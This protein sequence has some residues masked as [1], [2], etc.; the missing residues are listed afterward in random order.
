MVRRATKVR[1]TALVGLLAAI[2]A[3]YV[4]SQLDDPFYQ[5]AC[6][7]AFFGGSCATVFK[8]SYGHILSHWELV[9]KGSPLDVSLAA[10]GIVLYSAYFIA[11]S[12]PF[13]F[14]FREQIFLTVA[15]VGALFSCYLLYV[16]KYVLKDFCI[17]CTTFHLCNFCMLFLA[18]REYRDPK[19]FKSKHKKR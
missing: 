6:N 12:I 1:L 3:L 16:I 17:V 11:I 7:S 4:E 9:D 8:S 18:F 13:R 2:Y 5:P 14:P 19:V 15:S 10:T